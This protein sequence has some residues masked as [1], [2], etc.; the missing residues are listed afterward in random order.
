MK[1][2]ERIRERYPILNSYG[3][4]HVFLTDAETA[5][6]TTE[7]RIRGIWPFIVS[8]VL[9]FDATLKGR[10]RVNFDP[11]DVL[12]EI[13]V[14]LA[15]K[16]PL[17]TLERGKYITYA[18]V[19]IDRELYAIRDKARTIHAPRN[20]SGRMRQYRE[21]ETE[22]T[23]TDRRAKTA[24][25]VRRTATGMA[26]LCDE[27][28]AGLLQGQASEAPFDILAWAE[29]TAENLDAIKAG[30]RLLTNFEAMVVGRLS[31]LWGQPP[32]SVWLI[33]YENCCE[34][35]DVRRAKD[36]AKLKIRKHLNA[37][38]HPASAQ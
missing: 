25:D 36:R 22:G 7:E 1:K 8:R 33:A 30:V 19:I 37:I 4:K 34:Q 24:N 26:D 23:I 2:N 21:E 11:E 15:E 38:N 31:G 18:G 10:E 32:A 29:T 13:W 9:A 28:N 3:T 17:W 35:V 6:A 14:V 16:D 27:A 5:N 12:A 20:S